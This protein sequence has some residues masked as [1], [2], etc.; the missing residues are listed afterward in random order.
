MIWPCKSKSLLSQFSTWVLTRAPI[1]KNGHIGLQ[2]LCCSLLLLLKWPALLSCRTYYFHLEKHW[3]QPLMEP[4]MNICYIPLFQPPPEKRSFFQS[5][6]GSSSV[7][8]FSEN[9][10]CKAKPVSLWNFTIFLPVILVYNFH[11]FII[12][13][14]FCL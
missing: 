5:F 9:M 13:Q 4:D 6:L 7:G 8:S 12:L 11:L 3:F 10:L 2:P 1:L 14:Y